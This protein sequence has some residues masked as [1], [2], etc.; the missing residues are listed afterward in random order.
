MHLVLVEALRVQ[1]MIAI[2]QK[3]WAQAQRSV[4]EGVAR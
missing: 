2:R 3:R 1:A 4:E